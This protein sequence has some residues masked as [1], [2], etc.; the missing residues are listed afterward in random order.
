MVSK[1][2]KFGV[3]L[4]LLGMMPTHAGAVTPYEPHSVGSW[5]IIHKEDACWAYAAL[6]KGRAFAIALSPQGGLLAASHDSWEALDNHQGETLPV[7]YK[8][9]AGT[10]VKAEGLVGD[11]LGPR[12]IESIFHF[13]DNEELW[14][15]WARAFSVDVRVGD[16]LFG[17]FGFYLGRDHP[18]ND[19]DELLAADELQ[20]CVQTLK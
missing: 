12:S 13:S 16:D 4:A 19:S 20:R 7:I 1:W 17:S 8:F 11:V 9:S 6:D 14:R 5:K 18:R 15:A 2:T 3:C 10:Q